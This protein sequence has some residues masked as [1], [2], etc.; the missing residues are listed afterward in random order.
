MYIIVSLC[1]NGMFLAVSTFFLC[2][3]VLAVKESYYLSSPRLC[4]FIVISL[5]LSVDREDSLTS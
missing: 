2:V 5:D 1:Q 4:F 3:Y